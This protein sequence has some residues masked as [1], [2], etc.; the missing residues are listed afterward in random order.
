MRRRVRLR[1]DGLVEIRRFCWRD[2][3]VNRENAT[4]AV[5]GVGWV[6]SAVVLVETLLV[7]PL[8]IGAF[9]IVALTVLCGSNLSPALPDA[10][11]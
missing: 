7:S 6:A 1:R 11:R 3:V 2:V 4:L 5:L 9:G 8:L 10:R